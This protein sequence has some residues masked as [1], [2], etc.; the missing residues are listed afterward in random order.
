MEE[1]SDVGGKAFGGCGCVCVNGVGGDGGD[2]DE[3]QRCLSID[4]GLDGRYRIGLI[5]LA[6]GPD[7]GNEERGVRY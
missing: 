3:Q 5:G 2:D 4:G 7:K 6:Y 1:W